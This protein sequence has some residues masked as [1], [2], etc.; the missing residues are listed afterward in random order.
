MSNLKINLKKK[1]NKI[2]STQRIKADFMSF[3]LK[4]KNFIHNRQRPNPAK[5][6]GLTLVQLRSQQGWI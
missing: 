1:E 4:R 6:P 2:S 5:H 3:R